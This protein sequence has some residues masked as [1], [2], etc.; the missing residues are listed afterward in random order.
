MSAHSGDP[1]VFIR[2]MATRGSLGGLSRTARDAARA[3][4][5]AGFDIVLIET[6]GAG[7]SEVDIVR[8]AHTT[9]VVEAPGLGDDVQAIKAG[10]LEIADV[11]VV[12]KADRPGA[13]NTVRVLR[14]ML[15]LGH[16]AA[17]T[18]VRHHGQ[19]LT[20]DAPA[21]A[22]AD[23]ATWIPPLV[24]TVATLAIDDDTSGL[25]ALIEAISAHRRHLATGSQRAQI[26]RL[27]LEQELHER[28]RA[29]LMARLLRDLPR[30]TFDALIDD[31]QARHI[32]PH[33]AV[34][35][36]LS[37]TSGSAPR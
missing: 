24:Q 9:L 36:I 10:I 26:E 34:Q 21:G 12:N 30:D 37:H 27:H 29:E 22:D 15:E 7:Q 25:P 31:V 14:A 1:G 28:L 18:S 6:V 35:T 5:A 20:V 2:S 11:L 13:V 4:D 17:R 8:T 19:T 33:S 3:L 16:P 23:T 32:D